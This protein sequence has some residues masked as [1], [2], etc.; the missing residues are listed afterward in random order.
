MGDTDNNG[1][2]YNDA[3]QDESKVFA[4]ISLVCGIISLICSCCGWLSII[5]AVAAGVLGFISIS[6][7]EDGKG[8]AIAGIICGGIGLVTAVSILIF[9]AITGGIINAADPDALENIID[10]IENM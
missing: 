6:R 5:A 4:I 1:I 7:H 8:M 10:S 9:S 3:A 2:D